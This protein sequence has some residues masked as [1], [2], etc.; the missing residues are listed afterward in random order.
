MATYPNPSI[1][2]QIPKPAARRIAV[3]VTPE[4][5]RALRRGHPWL[6]DQAIRQQSHEGVPGDLAVI[7]D[8]K[9]RFLAVGLYD[10]HASIRVR[11]LQHGEPATIDRDWF[12]ARLAA[13][14]QLR[15]S[16][17]QQPPDAATTGYRLIHGENDG[18]PGLIIDRYED[19]LVL[20]LYTPAWIPHLRDVC[21][22]LISVSPAE[23]LV[24]RLSR[25]MLKQPQNLFGLS[26]G[27]ILSGLNLEGP[28]LF[29][30]NGLYF[31]AD[32]VQGQKTGFFLDQRDNRAR[33]EK[34][35]DD[36]T[37]LN[38]FAYTGGF[39]VYAARGGARNIVSIDSSVP[40]LEAATR[41]LVHNQHIATVAAVSH[42]VMAGDAFEVLARMGENKRRFDMVIIDPPAFAQKQTQMAQALSAYRRLTQLG[43]DVLQPGGI[44]AQASCSSRV[45]AETFFSTVN[46]AAGQAGRPLREIERTGHNTLDHPITFKEGAYLKCLFAVVP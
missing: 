20:K 32:P 28:V 21:A 15:A 36:K 16:L 11:I 25:A 35:A 9:R 30:E 39:S 26:D 43:L 8:R 12:R 31:E 24:L 38:V 5:E 18:L 19:T 41:N 37:V 23:R 33:V 34:L 4:A 14:A 44:L 2:F 10:P 22:A 40:A 1:L 42:E 7:F 29:Q 6:F 27:M 3:R 46:R 13:A 17:R 45:D